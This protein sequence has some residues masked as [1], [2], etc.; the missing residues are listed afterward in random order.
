MAMAIGD[1]ANLPKNEIV[2]P[3]LWRLPVEFIR[4]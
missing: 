2:W 4:L 3:A 1:I